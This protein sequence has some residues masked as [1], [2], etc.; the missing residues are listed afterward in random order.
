MALAY[1]DMSSVI[2]A[3]VKLPEIVL[4]FKMLFMEIKPG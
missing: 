2:E 1:V 4:K 3:Q